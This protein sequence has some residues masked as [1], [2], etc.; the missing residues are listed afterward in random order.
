MVF[1][2]RD[3]FMEHREVAVAADDNIR[4]CD[5]IRVGL[6]E[7]LKCVAADIDADGGLAVVVA[8]LILIHNKLAN[9]FQIIRTTGT[10]G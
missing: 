7:F 5:L 4:N 2:S 3:G 9:V 1:L 8:I 10:W 6:Y